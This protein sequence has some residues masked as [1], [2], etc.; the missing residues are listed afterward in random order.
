MN[1]NEGYLSIL[2]VEGKKLSSMIYMARDAGAYGAK[3]SGAG[4]GDCM[5]ALAPPKT[6]KVVKQAINKAGGQIIDIETD[7][8]GV[9]IEKI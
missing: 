9:K 5:I 7:V 4:I 6:R 1:F 3:L 8:P 2:G